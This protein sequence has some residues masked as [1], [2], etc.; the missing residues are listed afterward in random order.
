MEKAKICTYP[1]S[2]HALIHWEFILQCCAEYP[3]INLPDQEKNKKHKETT[4]LIRF[5]IYHIIGRCTAHGIILL[6]YKNVTCVN[7]NL[8]QIN[9]QKCTQEKS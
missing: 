3:N 7:N 5:H 6:K 8:H 1:Q 2:D 9:L 4:P